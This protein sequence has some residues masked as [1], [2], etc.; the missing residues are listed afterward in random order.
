MMA[1]NILPSRNG[2]ATLDSTWIQCCLYIT[3]GDRTHEHTVSSTSR[4]GIV[5]LNPGAV[6]SEPESKIPVAVYE[7]PGA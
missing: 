5:A 1:T 2:C 7:M 3:D 6:K 4:V